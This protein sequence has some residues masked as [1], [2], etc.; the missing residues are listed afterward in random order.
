VVPLPLI[1]QVSPERLE[2]LVPGLLEERITACCAVAQVRCARPSCPSRDRRSG[3]RPAQPSDRPLIQALAEGLYELT[4]SACRR[5][6]G[7]PSALPEHL[8]MKVRLV[9]SRA[10]RWPPART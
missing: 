7:T 10:G 8:R 5:T 3:S 9:D 2:W 1:N 4:A 6:P